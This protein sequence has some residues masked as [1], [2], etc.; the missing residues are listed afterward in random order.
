ME[1]EG[2]KGD[3]KEVKIYPVHAP[4]PRK[5]CKPHELHTCASKN[6]DLE[7]TVKHHNHTIDR[8]RKL[9]GIDGIAKW[10]AMLTVI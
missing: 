7:K 4:T 5:K 9:P 3:E 2:E 6:N 10:S 8:V 1:R